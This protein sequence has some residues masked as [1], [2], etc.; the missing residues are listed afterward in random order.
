M[1]GNDTK[2]KGDYS[3]HANGI[4]ARQNAHTDILNLFEQV[5]AG[6]VVETNFFS[7]TNGAGYQLFHS[8]P[9]LTKKLRFI[10]LK[11]A[12]E[13]GAVRWWKDEQEFAE[14]C[15][16]LVPIGC[17]P[18]PPDKLTKELK[19]FASDVPNLNASQQ[20]PPGPKPEPNEARVYI[21]RDAHD[22]PGS[23]VGSAE[24]GEKPRVMAHCRGTG[25]A[26]TK[27]LDWIVCGV[28]AGFES[29]KSAYSFEQ[30]MISPQNAVA[31]W[32]ERFRV[33]ESLKRAK[34]EWHW[35]ELVPG[36]SLAGP[37]PVRTPGQNNRST[38]PY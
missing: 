31:H 35:V 14:Y 32:G 3:W 9:G 22:G 8:E 2:T 5:L 4:R 6:K 30:A 1:E 15:R 28:Y 38:G 7:I 13:D 27:D 20:P 26:A 16:R 25:A 12:V 18:I 11:G 10:C 33:A 17:E 29:Y 24:H 36:D 23:Y 19:P 34:I 37:Q 21:L